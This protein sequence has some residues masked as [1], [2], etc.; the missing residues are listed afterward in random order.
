VESDQ[1]E[2]VKSLE[3]LTK[4]YLDE[5]KKATLRMQAQEIGAAVLKGL[6]G[7][8]MPFI[9]SL[10]KCNGIYDRWKPKV[11]SLRID[12]GQG[13]KQALDLMEKTNKLEAEMKKSQ[14]KAAVAIYGKIKSV[15]EQVTKGLDLVHDLGGR[16]TKAEQAEAKLTEGMEELNK[17]HPDYVKI[18]TVLFPAAVSI[19]LAAGAGGVEIKH[20][21]AALEVVKAS[22]VM[23]ED[24]LSAIREAATA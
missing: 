6:L 23:S 17:A 12:H 15:R 18:F 24:I 4:A 13:L 8:H 5:K 22:V 16:I 10:D 14:T 3:S 1:T 11:A 19:G 21:E 2:L 9:E 7:A 20:A